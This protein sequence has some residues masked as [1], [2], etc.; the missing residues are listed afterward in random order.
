[1]EFQLAC[2]DDQGSQ[3]DTEIFATLKGAIDAAEKRS[4]ATSFEIHGGGQSMRGDWK[5]NG[6]IDWVGITG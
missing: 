5:I 6:D 2:F 4:W 1:M 3:A